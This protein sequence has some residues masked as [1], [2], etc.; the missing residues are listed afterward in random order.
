MR[1][2]SIVV[3]LAMWTFS[4]LVAHA[5]TWQHQ[6]EADLLPEAPGSIL[7]VDSSTSSWDFNNS[8]NPDSTTATGGI[9]FY[10]SDRA[11]GGLGRRD[12]RI[13]TNDTAAGE[14]RWDASNG[15]TVEYRFKVGERDSNGGGARFNWADGDHNYHLDVARTRA[16]AVVTDWIDLD[17]AGDFATVRVAIDANANEGTAYFKDHTGA[18]AEIF[19]E[20]GPRATPRNSSFF[21]G[22]RC[23]DDPG[24]IIDLE[25]DYIRWTNEG[26]FDF[27]QQIDSF[28]SPP[29]DVP[30]DYSDN[31]VVALEDLNLV[32]F[33]WQAPG[34]GLPVEWVNFRPSG[35]VGLPELNEVLF[36]WQNMASIGTVPEPSGIVMVA[37]VLFLWRV[38]GLRSRKSNESIP[39]DL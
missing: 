15:I 8:D 27:T 7:N 35:N 33:N 11:P 5:V 1:L 34:P 12:W 30:G 4:S 18:E 31:G 36:N 24:C 10:T 39:Q 37:P 17:L 6:Y 13:G 14:S 9:L 25:I 28:V 29:T 32:L 19:V 22:P 26:I 20:I 2:R 23:A 38:F 3:A 21:A 16:R